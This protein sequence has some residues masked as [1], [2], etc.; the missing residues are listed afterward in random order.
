MRRAA[1]LAPIPKGTNDGIGARRLCAD[2]LKPAV[3]AKKGS[4]LE[5]LNR[6]SGP[7]GV[8][9]RAVREDG[10]RWGRNEPHASPPERTSP[11][12]LDTV[13]IFELAARR[14]CYGAVPILGIFPAP[15][16]KPERR[17]QANAIPTSIASKKCKGFHSAICWRF[18]QFATCCNVKHVFYYI[19]LR[20][21]N[22][23]A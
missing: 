21:A 9:L 20:R 15:N 17:L 22:V 8:G 13:V 19:A 6:G 3:R 16:S 7:I 2:S 5:G 14:I 11:E 12:L 23:A 18:R 1:A 10:W 4:G